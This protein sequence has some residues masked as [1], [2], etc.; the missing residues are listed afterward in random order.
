MVGALSTEHSSSELRVIGT[1]VY[2]LVGYKVQLIE[3]C[4]VFGKVFILFQQHILGLKKTTNLREN[5]NSSIKL[6]SQNGS[7]K[8]LYLED[9]SSN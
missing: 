3:Y 7:L 2:L 8:E 6:D 4:V 9:S 1:M 5:E